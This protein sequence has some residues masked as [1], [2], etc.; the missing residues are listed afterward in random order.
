MDEGGGINVNEVEAYQRKMRQGLNAGMLLGGIPLALLAEPASG[1]T[2]A[3]YVMA[4]IGALVLPTV[5]RHAVTGPGHPMYDLAATAPWLL[6]GFAA[7]GMLQATVGFPPR[8][9]WS[10]L[11]IQAAVVARLRRTWRRRPRGSGMLR[12]IDATGYRGQC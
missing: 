7:L 10:V 8:M 12:V 4:A 9:T 6:L 2:L 3:G 11:P 5:R 1:W